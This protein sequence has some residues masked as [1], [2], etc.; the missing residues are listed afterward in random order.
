MWRSRGWLAGVVV[1][2]AALTGCGKTGSAAG[3]AEEGPLPIAVA[4]VQAK[5]VRRT[6]DVTGTL[7][8]VEEVTVSSE[9]EG[10]VVRIAADL[11]DRVSAG[12][13]LVVLDPEKLQYRLDQQRAA[14]GR[15]LARFGVVDVE[16]PL[17]E[18]EKTPDVQKALAERAQA[19]QAYRRAEQLRKTE[20]L[21][22]QALDD[23]DATLKAKRADYESAL[24]NARNLRADIDAE[25]ATLKLA[26]ASLRDSTIRAPF[27]AYI[28]KRLVSLGAF[29]KTQTAVMALVKV[30]PLKLTAEVPEKM[31]A[32][33]KVG[34]AL[35]LIVEAQPG[36][37]IAGE[38]AR[39]S[40]AVNPQTRAFP[41]EGRVPNPGGILKPGSF[42]RVHIVTDLIEKVLTVPANALQYRYGVN[43]VFVVQGDRLKATEIKIGDRVG[44]RIEVVSGVDA[45]VSIAAKDVERLAD[46]QRITV[47]ANADN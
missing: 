5:E 46:G 35:S 1:V 22:Q 18:I 31:A 39:L 12:Q 38:I 34:Q 36:T 21:P 43:R 25:R 41:L 32:W 15:A 13:P 45:G 27:D 20:L 16:A 6:I 26:E 19:E 17:P 14:L 37:P 33:V 11:G 28:Q 24:Q 44:E 23:A 3:K 4:K 10:R 2:S 47:S 30:D 9:V 29:V 42:A 8:A 7:A 40:P